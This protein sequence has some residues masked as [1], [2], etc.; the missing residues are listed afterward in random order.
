[1]FCLE[2]LAAPA[3][4][5]GDV[6]AVA[7]LL[8]RRCSPRPR[9]HASMGTLPQYTAADALRPHLGTPPLKHA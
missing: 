8:A 3:R 5:Q 1:M 2:L 9:H 6:L 4:L 7:G